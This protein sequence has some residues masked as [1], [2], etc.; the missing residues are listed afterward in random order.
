MTDTH[1]RDLI[2][3]HIEAERLKQDKTW[4]EQNH[5]AGTGSPSQTIV[6][7]E[8]RAACEQAAADGSLT[9]AHIL[10]K[11]VCEAL[12]E[13]DYARLRAELLQVAAV[14]ISWIEAIERRPRR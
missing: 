6:A 7:I 3:L 13:G 4:G 11:E 2:Y 5:P 14:A 9:W 1:P 12:A 8:A 10:G